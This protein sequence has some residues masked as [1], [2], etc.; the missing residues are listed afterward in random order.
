MGNPGMKIMIERSGNN[1]EW[2]GEKL[3]EIPNDQFE[4]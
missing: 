3:M 1:L 2:K 4:K